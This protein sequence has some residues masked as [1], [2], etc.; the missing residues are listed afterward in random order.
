[1]YKK[2]SV[3]LLMLL[4]AALAV[5]SSAF[6]EP[7]GEY[8]VFAQCPTENP[9]VEGCVYSKT[10]SGEFVAGK[11]AVPI[12]K[13]ITLQGG[14]YENEETGEKFF[15]GA[16]NGESLSK[17]P[18]NVPGGLAGLVNCTQIEEP[19]VR[20]LCELVFEKGLTGVTE[21]TELAGPA[22]S[23]IVVNPGLVLLK[24]GVAVKMKV[25]VHL[26][27]PLLGSACY[28]GSNSEPIELELTTGTTSP[29]PPN[30]PITGSGGEQSFNAEGTIATI[31]NAELVDNSFAVPSVNGCGGL[32]SAILDPIIDLDLG[33]PATDG[34]NTAILKGMLESANAG[35][36]RA[37]S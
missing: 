12:T 18:Q 14:I 1:M 3:A 8:A 19:V 31:K 20:L 17:T 6:A 11:K 36:V 28:I 15:V 33:I 30:K 35:V 2:F 25:K 26:E 13:A 5:A 10:E 34:H 27:N 37:H 23:T 4:C 29:E 9:L 24:A 16:K 7:T 32:A 21:T 22:A